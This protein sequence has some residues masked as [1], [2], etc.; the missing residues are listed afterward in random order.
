[1]PKLATKTEVKSLDTGLHTPKKNGKEKPAKPARE[2]KPKA[3][4]KAAAK[5][6]TKPVLYSAI[7]ARI[8]S[9]IN[10]VTAETAKE[11]LA[12]EVAAEKVTPIL[13]DKHGNK[14]VTHNN[15][16]NRP[17]DPALADMWKL[18][19]LRKKWKLNGETIIVDKYGNVQSGQHRLVGLI[20][21]HQEWELDRKKPKDEQAWASYWD[22]E[23]TLEGIVIFG[24][25]GDDDTVNTIDTT[26][27]RSAVD[28][29]YRSDWFEDE[30]AEKR[31]E[32][33]GICGRAVKLLWE[34]TQARDFSDAPRRPHSELVDF[35]RRHPS[36]I[37]CTRFVRDEAD[38]TKLGEYVPAGY[39]AALLYL[40]GSATSDSEKYRKTDSE[41]GMDWELHDVAEAFWS[42]FASNGKA[43]EKIRD[44]INAIPD[45]LPGGVSMQ[46]RL[47]AI[48]NGWNLYSAKKKITQ[49]DCTV[50][51]TFDDYG[52][53]QVAETP[54][55]G[56][57]D[58]EYVVEKP[59]K[60]EAE[61]PATKADSARHDP[62]S[63]VCVKD[64]GEHNWEEDDQ[65]GY[66]TKCLMPASAKPKSGKK[67]AK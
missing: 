57:I 34:R 62:Y 54:R 63:D 20:F 9:G 29:L 45:S 47:A 67:G 53:P 52:V 31:K 50:E 30:T 13:T 2:T 21:A 15:A 48:I 37:D 22:T 6:E 5:K 18:E 49:E 51:V 39:A 25:D 23:P 28:V 27:P 59:A 4:K 11:L 3:K 16:T 41:S 14:I 26:K 46:L 1:M 10:P 35:V 64:G 58:V 8:F 38:G 33:A 24:I 12:W 43:T 17:F 7:E 40:M 66:C 36:L 55:I 32:L 42:D 56:G 61:K 19:V 44:A 65:G 60:E